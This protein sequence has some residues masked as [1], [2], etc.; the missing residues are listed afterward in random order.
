MK[1]VTIKELAIHTGL[2]TSTV[3]RILHNRSGVSER[4]RHKVRDAIHELGFGAWSRTHLAPPKDTL[5]FLFLL[6]D[7]HTTFADE[8][9]SAVLAAPQIVDDFN[10]VPEVKRISLRDGKYLN[11]ALND[12][13]PHEYQ[14]VAVFAVDAPGVRQAIDQAVENGI[15]VVTMVSD[16][17][18]SRRH[19]FVGIDNT[20]AGRVAGTLMGRFIGTK[21]GKVALIA[22]SMQQ[23]DH[24]DRLYGFEQIIRMSYPNLEILPVREGS[25]F[26]EKNAAIMRELIDNNPDLLG[27]YSFGAGNKGIIKVLDEYEIGR[28]LVVIVH[29]LSK[30]VRAAL[31]SEKIDAVLAQ[32]TGH[33][34]RSAVR[35]LRALHCGSKIIEEQEKMNVEF[36]LADNLP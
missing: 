35:V 4:A 7:L 12:V 6:P 14:G 36:Y 18:T 9:H 11:K 25:S 2:S 5:R 30:E 31:E 26:S 29:E 20:A 15:N 17:P 16:I 32:N 27:V 28:E 21:T 33:I 1:K 3:D 19:Y 23:R 13:D 34:A 24:I 10:V 8:L 22:G